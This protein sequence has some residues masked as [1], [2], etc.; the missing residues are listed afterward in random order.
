MSLQK[1]AKNHHLQKACHNVVAIAI[2][3]GRL[4]RPTRCERCGNTPKPQARARRDPMSGHMRK[5]YAPL[6]AHHKDYA[7]PFEIQWICWRCHHQIHTDGQTFDY[8]EVLRR[9]GRGT[10]ARLQ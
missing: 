2:R 1:T 4:S 5:P 7:K 9:R 6:I 3:N 8:N 10:G